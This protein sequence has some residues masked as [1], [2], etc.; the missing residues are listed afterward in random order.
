MKKSERDYWD[1]RLKKDETEERAK[2]I[3]KELLSRCPQDL[4]KEEKAEIKRTAVSIANKKLAQTPPDTVPYLE[5]KVTMVGSVI[6]KPETDNF[7]YKKMGGPIE[8]LKGRVLTQKGAYRPPALIPPARHDIESNLVRLQ[9]LYD[10]A[11]WGQIKLTGRVWTKSKGKWTLSKNKKKGF[12]KEVELLPHTK[13]V[14]EA[15]NKTWQLWAKKLCPTLPPLGRDFSPVTLYSLA[16]MKGINPKDAKDYLFRHHPEDLHKA[17][18]ERRLVRNDPA[19]LAEVK[20]EMVILI[21]FSM[22]S[23]LLDY[24]KNSVRRNK[25]PNYSGWLR[26]LKEE[27]G[28]TRSG[29]RKFI[30][31]KIQKGI[32]PKD[33]FDT[34]PPDAA[35]AK[36]LKTIKKPSKTMVTAAQ[37]T[38]EVLGG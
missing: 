27:F 12:F 37:H 28:Y 1:K 7:L 25:N 11:I 2:E 14:Q 32:I 34:T 17:V 33:F 5:E 6:K 19:G 16:T 38:A 31:R 36:K 24:Y 10:F 18:F 13:E 9:S 35:I 3:E 30:V 29:A 15:L 22:G 8:D 21:D 23:D 4:T 26:L 20:K